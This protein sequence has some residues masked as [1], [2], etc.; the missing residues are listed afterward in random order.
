MPS[1][2]CGHRPGEPCR[3]PSSKNQTTAC[4]S[5]VNLPPLPESDPSPA[6]A[7][8]DAALAPLPAAARGGAHRGP[9]QRDGLQ[10]SLKRDL[11]SLLLVSL[12]ALL[13]ALG[14]RRTAPSAAAPH[15]NTPTRGCAAV[16]V[17]PGDAGRRPL[18]TRRETCGDLS[19]DSAGGGELPAHRVLVLRLNWTRA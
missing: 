3:M 6:P 1:P 17:T 7:G 10:G 18:G 8:Q 13:A 19:F 5:Q 12:L 11:S 9:N 14:N 4:C 2:P 15:T 16:F